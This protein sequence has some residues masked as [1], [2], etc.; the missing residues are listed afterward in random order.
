MLRA[1]IK[2]KKWDSC[3]KKL[4]DYYSLDSYKAKFLYVTQLRNYSEITP[5]VKPLI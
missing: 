3:N 5:L 1:F 4:S 2:E